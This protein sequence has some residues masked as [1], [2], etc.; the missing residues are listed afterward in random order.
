MSPE[1][2]ERSSPDAAL[3]ILLV[4]DDPLVRMVTAEELRAAGLCVIEAASAAEAYDAV[5]AGLAVDLVFTD[6]RTEGPLDGYE[7]AVRLRAEHPHLPVIITSGHMDPA[8]ATQVAPFL[9][10][11]YRVE[12]VIALIRAQFM[13]PL[14]PPSERSVP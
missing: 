12:S 2:R 3:C 10:K 7:F 14:C 13:G 5:V 9:A 8:L 11:P 6:V 1:R 4:E